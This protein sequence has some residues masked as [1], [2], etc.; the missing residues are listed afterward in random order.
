MSTRNALTDGAEGQTGISPLPVT[1]SA[2][3]SMVSGSLPS[4]KQ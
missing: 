1:E 3:L 2:Q 4:L